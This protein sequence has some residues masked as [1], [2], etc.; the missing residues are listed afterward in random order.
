MEMFGKILKVF[1]YIFLTIGTIAIIGTLGCVGYFG[2]QAMNKLTVIGGVSS[3]DSS[4]KS[5]K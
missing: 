1:K 3:Q 2:W 5:K 4:P